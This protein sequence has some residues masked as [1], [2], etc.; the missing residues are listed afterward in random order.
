M[1]IDTEGITIIND[2]AEEFNKKYSELREKLFE[3][4]LSKVHGDK[5]KEELEKQIEFVRKEFTRLLFDAREKGIVI[6][7]KKEI[8]GGERKKW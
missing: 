2:P 8:N 6:N 3:L 5:D 1:D 4:R 7:E